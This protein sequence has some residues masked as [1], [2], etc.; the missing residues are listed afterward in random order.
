VL[1]LRPL[2]AEARK[3][4]QF[5]RLAAAGALALVISIAQVAPVETVARVASIGKGQYPIV[6]PHGTLIVD[7][8]NYAAEIQG[9][10]DEVLRHSE[11]GDPVF[12][13]AWSAPPLYALTGRRNPTY[14]DSLVDLCH[15]PTREKQRRVCRELLSGGAK[16]VVHRQG[17]H[18]SSGPLEAA[19]PLI[20]ECL[21]ENFEPFAQHGP[22]CILRRR[23]VVAD[24]GSDR[25]R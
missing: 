21:R 10:V 9:V 8:P 18:F 25:V 13:T 22:H 17:W 5:R 23:P 24:R 19:C 1:L 16:L 11:E 3:L 12:V 14:Y 15:R 7:D 4:P 2:L 6:A 20:D